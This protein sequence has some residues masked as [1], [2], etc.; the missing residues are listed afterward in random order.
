MKQL[1]LLFLCLVLALPALAEEPDRAALADEWARL[2]TYNETIH[3]AEA[4]ACAYAQRYFASGTW[5]DLLQAR[6][7]A[8]SAYTVLLFT[9]VPT[10]ALLEEQYALWMQQGHDLT[11]IPTEFALLARDYPEHVAAMAYL[12]EAL[13]HNVFWQPH[14]NTLQHW[15]QLHQDILAQERSL[16]CNMTNGLVLTAPEELR[17]A[18]QERF[19]AACPTLF[20]DYAAWGSDLSALEAAY[21]DGLDRLQALY[22]DR[23]AVLGETEIYATLLMSLIE[24]QDFAAI[25]A[26][27]VPIAGLPS[28]LPEPPWVSP[29]IEYMWADE[30][31]ELWCAMPG[32]SLDNLS[33]TTKLTWEG[34]SRSAFDDYVKELLLSGC[35][36]HKDDASPEKRTLYLLADDSLLALVWTEQYVLL[37]SPES[38]VC[39]AP[40]WFMK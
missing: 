12:L 19:T 10:A 3:Q 33:I 26:N 32:M 21:A 40:N 39:L 13:Q 7:A 2:L 6:L 14:Q 27:A 36:M 22:S 25:H 34:I 29:E 11:H 23:Y 28:M 31:G 30:A 5:E 16:I 15:T 37:L 18:E 35:I 24:K 20:A 9:E 17:A 4:W 8:S 38:T 1:L